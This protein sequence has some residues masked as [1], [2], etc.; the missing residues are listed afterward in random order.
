MKKTEDIIRQTG[1]KEVHLTGHS[2][3]G[4]TVNHSIANSAYIRSKLTSAH[5]Y[6]AAANPIFAN[7]QNVS[8]KNR[9][10]LEGKVTHHRIEDDAVSA[11]FKTN[12]P[13]GKVKT[14]KQKRT[15]GQ[16]LLSAVSPFAGA[17]K[18]SL[19]NHSLSNFHGEPG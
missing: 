6:N 5:T 8:R 18:R 16:R 17:S 19:D 3:G 4:G 11:G 1:A 15:T 14:Y 7:K 13:F 2:L 9:K 12:T 10:A